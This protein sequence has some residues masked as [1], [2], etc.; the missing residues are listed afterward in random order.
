MRK[1]TVKVVIGLVVFSLLLAGLGGLAGA[2]SSIYSV[3]PGDS[4]WKI[5]QKFETTVSNLK[6]LNNLWSNYLYPGQKLYVPIAGWNYTVKKGDSLWA[7]SQKTGVS[8]TTLKKV[9]N[10]ST[11]YL[12]IGQ[13]LIIPTNGDS[14]NVP[15]G[16]VSFTQEDIDLIARVIYAEARGE[17]YKGQLAVGAVL[18]N[19][20]KHPEFPNTVQGVVFQPLAFE[21]VADGQIWLTPNATAYKAAYAAADGQDPTYGAL[22]F[23]NP[24]KVSPNNWIWSRKVTIKIGNH[25]FAI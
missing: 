1:P 10:L 16:P 9:N 20:V 5:A 15:S 4:L 22:F 19:R 18:V 23:Y 24:T 12:W 17:S 6:Q 25:S 3:Q 14:S 13:V 2:A 8:V 21:S 7:I 11:T